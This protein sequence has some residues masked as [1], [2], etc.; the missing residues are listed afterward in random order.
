MAGTSLQPGPAT[1]GRTRCPAMT[2]RRRIIERLGR[3]LPLA[4]TRLAAKEQRLAGDRRDHRELERLGDE[5][6]RL[7]TLPGEEPL[8]IGGDENHRHFERVEKLVHGV[9]TRTAVG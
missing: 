4:L 5:E 8:R 7:R 9:E 6:R 3:R 2:R 1:S